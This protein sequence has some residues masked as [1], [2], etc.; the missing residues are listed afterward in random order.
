MFLIDYEKNETYQLSLYNRSENN[1]LR[2]E[3]M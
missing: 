1:P 3:R 2:K